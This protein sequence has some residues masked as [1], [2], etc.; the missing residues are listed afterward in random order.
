MKAAA[1][2]FGLIVLMFVITQG[3]RYCRE[4][5]T[6]SAA[7]QRAEDQ[8]SAVSKQLVI[9]NAHIVDTRKIEVRLRMQSR[10]EAMAQRYANLAI[11][12]VQDAVTTKAKWQIIINVFGSDGRLILQSE[13]EDL[14]QGE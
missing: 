7:L 11:G 6:M 2:W 10:S 8:I 4:R 14:R 1:K 3:M 5:Q 9:M 12:A 13:I